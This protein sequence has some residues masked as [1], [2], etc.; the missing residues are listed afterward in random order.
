MGLH[1]QAS[2]TICFGLQTR[3]PGY[4][5]LAKKSPWTLFAIETAIIVIPCILKLT[6]VSESPGLL[7]LHLGIPAGIIC[8]LP[9]APAPSPASL[10][11][12]HSNAPAAY[13]TSPNAS[14]PIPPL[15]SVTIYRAYTMLLCVVAILGVDFPVFPRF[16]AKTESFGV[17]IMDIGVGSFVF[18]QGL[19]SAIPLLRDPSQLSR[20]LSSKIGPSL[21]KASPL[22]ALGL[23]RLIIVK[24]TGYPEHVTEYGVHWNFFLTFGLLPVAATCFH[25]LFLRFP[26]PLLG[27][28]VTGCY[29]LVLKKTSC[30]EWA[31]GDVREGLIGQNKEGIVSFFGFLAINLLGHSIGTLILPPSPSHFRRRQKAQNPNSS[32]S[33]SSN[34]TYLNP[35][36]QKQ[37]PQ[38]KLGKTAIE[39]CSYSVVWWVLFGVAWWMGGGT[40]SVSRRL[41]NLPYVLWTTAVNSSFI[42]G[43]MVL[44]ILFSPRV[45][46]QNPVTPPSPL[47]EASPISSPSRSFE[48]LKLTAN[49]EKRRVS[50]EGRLSARTSEEEEAGEYLPPPPKT[51][52]P[53]L[54]APLLTEA[55]NKNSM[56]MFLLSNLMTG[57]I[58]KSYETMYASDSVAMWI[59]TTY[60]VVCCAIMWAARG[61]KLINL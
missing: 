29:E 56:T 37:S 21:K 41:A 15:V 49:G 17:S 27:L 4:T 11:Y 55:I 2:I 48:G 6:L 10:E 47:I 54:K 30:E 3:F 31:L 44:E 43:F 5:S 16:H 18:A 61:K 60:T 42:L 39:L 8:L 50:E 1:F 32:T 38:R 23:I 40:Y 26:M 33:N 46:K 35:A 58:N 19:V 13:T 57:A 9:S 59:L 24:V 22:L 51:A 25:P 36:G 14:I 45:P 20:P 53:A 52:P 28:L 7:L 34:A 12:S